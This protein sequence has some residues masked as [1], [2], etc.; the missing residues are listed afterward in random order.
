MIRSQIL[1]IVDNLFLNLIASILAS[2]SQ[3]VKFITISTLFLRQKNICRFVK[4][5]LLLSLNQKL[6]F[7]LLVCLK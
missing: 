5:I 4:L 6:C 3:V 7:Y 1:I 2:D